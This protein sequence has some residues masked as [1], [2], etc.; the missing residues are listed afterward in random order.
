MAGKK[1][2]LPGLLAETM[3]GMD[4]RQI[5]VFRLRLAEVLPVAIKQAA[6]LAKTP[7]AQAVKAAQPDQAVKPKGGA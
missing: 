3:A 1:I 6:E 7:P 2:D 4:T 5:T